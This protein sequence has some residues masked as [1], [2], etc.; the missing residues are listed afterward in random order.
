MGELKGKRVLITGASAG[1]GAAVAR[2]F[3]AEGAD[4]V[5]TARR[6]ERLDAL[7]AE[8]RRGGVR[9]LA[10]SADVT[11]DGDLERVVG[12]AREEL[13]GLDVVLANAGFG[14]TGK[15]E[16]LELDDFRRQ[17]ETNVFGVLRTVYASLEELKRSQGRLGIVGSVAGWISRPGGAPYS[18]SKFAVRAL[19]QSLRHELAPEGVSVTLISPGFVESEIRRVGNDG[20]LAEEPDPVPGWLRMPSEKAA[21]EI[22]RALAQRRAEAVITGH[23]KALVFLERHS[24]WVLEGVAQGLAGFSKSLG[25]GSGKNRAR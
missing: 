13:G 4:L 25:W 7:A 5:L 3:A 20:A 24:P 6:G 12:A 23:G 15:V 8:L 9:A 17:F 18:M 14:V 2:A 21:R 11:L 16:E 22:V 10:L 19:A 1:I